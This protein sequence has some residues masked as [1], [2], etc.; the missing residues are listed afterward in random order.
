METDTKMGQ[1]R[2]GML[3]ELKVGIVNVNMGGG[4]GVKAGNEK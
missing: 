2:V 3:R 4:K 1:G